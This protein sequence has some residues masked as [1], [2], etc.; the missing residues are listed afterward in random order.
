MEYEL[1][2]GT[3][4]APYIPADLARQYYTLLS[5]TPTVDMTVPASNVVYAAEWLPNSYKVAFEFGGGADSNGAPRVEYELPYGSAIAPYIPDPSLAGHTIY[6]WLPAVDATVPGSNV[7]YS[8]KWRQNSYAVAFDANGGEG[9]MDGMAYPYEE[10][11]GIVS[12]AFTKVGHSFAGWATEKDGEVVY[13]DGEAIKF[14]VDDADTTLYAVWS[15]NSYKVAFDFGGGVDSNGDVRV[16]YEL[17]Y[18]TELAPYIPA[19]PTRQHYTFLSWTTEIAET[20]P[21]CDVEYVADWKRN[22]WIVTFDPMGGTCADETKTVLCLDPVGELPTAERDNHTFAGW[23]TEDG[24]EVADSTVPDGDS[25]Y[26]A[27]WTFDGTIDVRAAVVESDNALGKVTGAKDDVKP[28]TKLALKAT[29]NK[30]AA[31]VGWFTNGVLA[32][33][34]ASYS[35]VADGVDDV[36]FEARFMAMGDDHLLVA[37]TNMAFAVNAKVALALDD[38]FSVDS[39]S[40][41]TS[42]AISGLPSGV[43]Y[44]AKTATFSGAPTK[45]GIYYVTCVAKNGNGYQYSFTEV[46]N[47]GQAASTDTDAGSIGADALAQLDNLVTGVACELG[48]FA[49][50]TAVSGLPTGLKF[51]KNTGVISGVPTKPGKATVTFT[52]RN[53][54]KSVR[55]VIVEDGGM[56]ALVLE[57]AGTNAT[58]TV[59]GGG[60]Y[61][62]GK[63]VTIKATAA[64]GGVFAGWYDADGNAV[65]GDADFRTASFPYVMGIGKT[66][67][68]AAFAPEGD[69]KASLKVY[70]ADA[71]TGKDGSLTLDLGACVESLSLPKLAVSGLPS[72][73][74]Y[75]T[76]TLKV[77]GKATKPGV[78]RVKV[79]ATN[80]SVTKATDDT[81]ALFDVTVPNF[82]SG[83]MPG[84][85]YATGAYGTNDVGVAFGP[86]RVDCRTAEGWTAKVAGLPAG[87]KYDA[88]TGKI[89][90]IPTK[91][92]SYTVTFTLSKKGEQNEVATITL[93]VE[94]LPAWAVGTFDGGLLATAGADAGAVL[95]L[96]Q[97]LTVAAN[98]KISG[99]VI[100]AAGTWTLS[101]ASFDRY[102]AESGAYFATVIGKSGKQSFTNEV[103]VSAAEFAG[104]ARGEA[105]MTGADAKMEA[106][107]NLWK[108]EP[109]KTAAKPFANKKLPIPVGAVEGAFTSD[110]IELK[111]AS[112]GAVTASG[113][114]VTGV[115]EKTGKDVV[116]SATCSSTLLP[117][118]DDKY[119]LY[120]FFPRKVD[121]KGNVTF[122]G[123]AAVIPLAWDGASFALKA[124]E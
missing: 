87:L 43:K 16:E 95:G 79:A 108:T 70:V 25:T 64:K 91:A 14:G 93:N 76:K 120:L 103:Q 48:G 31:F 98:G 24:S 10:E 33:A 50:A 2:Y 30:G 21:P 116:Y 100:D 101:A 57:T 122:E 110:T 19:D 106:V 12:N 51:D 5:W 69:D 23:R 109:W 41:V 86:D 28:G 121:A 35:Y 67:L 117:Q 112:S 115:N 111:F 58:G 96:A 89:S 13:A 80:T 102:D 123:Y 61:A 45:A 18:G 34:T 78:Y 90:G 85:L 15:V 20:V 54:G 4:L 84:L 29:A 114:F 66:V 107:Q 97:G 22:T 63:K 113:K 17:P 40:A 53:K 118:G 38:C 32:A 74:K 83:K 39:E 92:G 56:Y 82:E 49:N 104:A 105:A 60:V 55:T 42:L 59:T 77:S 1:P 68:T 119:E 65:S 47:V 75:D 124:G 62:A 71:E 8:A 88:K 99:K 44:D 27:K 11:M 3:E 46:W 9:E 7:V 37:G 94:A 26:Y 52:G 73:L 6:S 36:A 81:T 72:G